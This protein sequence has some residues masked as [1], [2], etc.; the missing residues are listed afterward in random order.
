MTRILL[1]LLLAADALKWREIAEGLAKVIEN[2][3]SPC[4]CPHC[5]KA[6]KENVD[7]A[8]AAFREAGK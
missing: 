2:T 4:R 7:A 8:L 5:E 3:C 1:A 6:H